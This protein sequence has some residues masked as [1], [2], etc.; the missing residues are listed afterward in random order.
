MLNA[1]CLFGSVSLV[2][3]VVV[4]TYSVLMFVKHCLRIHNKTALTDLIT[5]CDGKCTDCIITVAYIVY[6]W[7]AAMK[8]QKC[9]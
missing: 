5:L 9:C 6:H 7:Q 3:N 4:P 8:V 1:V 2:C